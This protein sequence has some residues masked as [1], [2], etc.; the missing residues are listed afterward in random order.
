M[1][2]FCVKAHV[3][4]SAVIIQAI[5]RESGILNVYAEFVGRPV[6]AHNQ[7]LALC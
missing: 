1:F 6:Y 7:V 3:S 2:V 4:G 5:K